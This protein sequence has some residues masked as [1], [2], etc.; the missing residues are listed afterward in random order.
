M[1]APPALTGQGDFTD[2]EAW[3]DEDGNIPPLQYNNV[4]YNT[5]YPQNGDGRYWF[6][7]DAE[8]TLNGPINF[9]RQPKF[10]HRQRG[11]PVERRSGCD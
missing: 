10:F 1:S 7:V 9:L 6:T 11:A 4:P 3:I 2:P 5:N 8:S